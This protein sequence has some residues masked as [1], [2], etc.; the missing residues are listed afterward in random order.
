VHEGFNCDG[1]QTSC[2]E[3]TNC[4][5]KSEGEIVIRFVVVML[6]VGKVMQNRA[7]YELVEQHDANE[8]APRNYSS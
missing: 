6:Y 1:H 8:S 4:V 3:H 7:H 5:F 2:E